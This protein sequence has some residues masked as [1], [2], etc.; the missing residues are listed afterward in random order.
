MGNKPT[1]AYL[2]KQLREKGIPIPKG[3][4]I[5][6]LEHRLAHYLP[7]HGYLVRLAKQSSRLPGHAV[8]LLT[9]MKVVYWIPNSEMARDIIES[10]LVFVLGRSAEPPNDTTPIEVPTDYGKVDENGGDDDTD[11]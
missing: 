9:D 7:G 2:T 5:T 11:S 3:A 1:K 8:T 6:A 10:K 4:T